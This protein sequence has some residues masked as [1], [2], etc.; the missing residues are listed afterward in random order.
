M[1]S[2]VFDSRK[3]KHIWPTRS[4]CEVHREIYDLLCIGF[5]TR[6]WE[7][8]ERIVPLLEEAYLDGVKMTKKLVE[9]K[10]AMPDWDVNLPDAEK[11][12]LR[13][14]RIHLTDELG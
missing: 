7:L 2:E 14:L 8:V 1:Y 9:N 13:Q 10:C 6:D 5:D 4:I 3:G 12:R 11:Q